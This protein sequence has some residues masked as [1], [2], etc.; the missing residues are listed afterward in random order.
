MRRKPKVFQ[1][2]SV[3]LGCTEDGTQL[4][5]RDSGGAA[6]FELKNGVLHKDNKTTDGTDPI[7]TVGR[8]S[9]K[10]NDNGKTVDISFNVE[11]EGYIIQI[12]GD[13]HEML[14]Y[15]LELK[16]GQEW[17]FN[18]FKDLWDE[19]MIRANKKCKMPES[20]KITDNKIL[21]IPLT[22]LG[23]PEI[24]YDTIS[25]TVDLRGWDNMAWRYS[26]ISDKIDH[27]TAN[28]G[29]CIFHENGAVMVECSNDIEGKN[30]P[31]P[32][33]KGN[34]KY[35]KSFTKMINEI[36]SSKKGNP[37]QQV[38]IKDIADYLTLNIQ[39]IELDKDGNMVIKLSNKEEEDGRKLEYNPSTKKAYYINLSGTAEE[40]K[41][42]SFDPDEKTLSFQAKNNVKITFNLNGTLTTRQIYEALKTSQMH[43]DPLEVIYNNKWGKNNTKDHLPLTIK[44][45]QNVDG[46]NYIIKME[47]DKSYLVFN[48][49]KKQ[50]IY[51]NNENRVFSNLD[52][53]YKNDELLFSGQEYNKTFRFRINENAEQFFNA[54]PY[55]DDKLRPCKPESIINF[56]HVNEIAKQKQNNDELIQYDEGKEI[57]IQSDGEQLEFC[58]YRKGENK[59]NFVIPIKDFL[60]DNLENYQCEYNGQRYSVTYHD[61]ALVLESLDKE[62]DGVL[63]P[64]IIDFKTMLQEQ[65][66]DAEQCPDRNDMKSLLIRIKAAKKKQ[67]QA[68][69][70]FGQIDDCFFEAEDDII[71]AIYN[72]GE[73]DEDIEKAAAY[74]H[75]NDYINEYADQKMTEDEIKFFIDI[76]DSLNDSD[77]LAEKIE[78]QIKK[79]IQA[80]KN[81]NFNK[82]FIA[83][84]YIAEPE[85][86]QEF[87][88]V[89]IGKYS[90]NIQQDEYSN[91][92]EINALMAYGLITDDKHQ[93]FQQFCTNCTN[94]AQRNNINDI[95]NNAP[96]IPTIITDIVSCKEKK[97]NNNP[98]KEKN[99]NIL[100]KSSKGLEGLFSNK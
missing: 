44:T 38:S 52:C 81:V 19:L 65:G 34:V 66:L 14:K 39:P 93:T 74:M 60:F 62:E 64:I 97:I 63:Q 90:Q 50:F 56:K 99:L 72:N 96:E 35:S 49:T 45:V 80:N 69:G 9:L 20:I 32:L 4:A 40:V 51:V 84:M 41:D 7:K 67:N 47:D 46:D 55:K 86:V 23:Y 59:I 25:G 16:Q 6:L 33:F 21:K 71:S 88:N 82:I 54:N 61:D 58:L 5:F 89:F 18:A 78:D 42:V 28:K 85:Q 91:S 22:D 73:S 95:P 13:G 36:I 48:T 68:Q 92:P 3:D 100:Q 26:K 57:T 79:N 75:L 24:I 87:T 53:F 94:N 76:F 31:A 12:S 30:P 37:E 43:D 17:M 8:L 98:V 10:L 1:L 29:K 27:L 11:G 15:L 2:D 83:L 77:A 70:Q